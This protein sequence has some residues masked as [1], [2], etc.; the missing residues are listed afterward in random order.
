MNLGTVTINARLGFFDTQSLRDAYVDGEKLHRMLMGVY[1]G[2]SHNLLI[3]EVSMMSGDQLDIII[4][5]VEHLQE[6]VI[7]DRQSA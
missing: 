2:S 6:N 4:D 3:D 5:C 1:K 7:E